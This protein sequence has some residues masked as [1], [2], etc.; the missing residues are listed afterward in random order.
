[1]ACG[2]AVITTKLGTEDY[3]YDCENALVIPPK[4]PEVL[5]DAIIKLIEQPELAKHLATNGIET[6]CN[7]TWHKA[8]NRLEEIINKV[9]AAD[10]KKLF[11]D[12]HDIDSGNIVY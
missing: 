10:K 4:Q 1:M 2:T 12:I 7:F 6:A 5:A 8:T 9:I 3:A 11:T